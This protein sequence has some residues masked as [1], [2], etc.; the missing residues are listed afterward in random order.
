M[1]VDTKKPIKF[2]TDYVLMELVDKGALA[3][4]AI[5]ADEDVERGLFKGIKVQINPETNVTTTYIILSNNKKDLVLMDLN[6]FDFLLIETFANTT[7]EM[8][9]YKGVKE[10]QDAAFNQT[11]A[12]MSDMI[13]EERVTA[14]KDLI[15]LESYTSIPDSFGTGVAK[16]I[17]KDVTKVPSRAVAAGAGNALKSQVNPTHTSLAYGPGVNQHTNSVYGHQNFA[18]HAAHSTYDTTYVAKG[19]RKPTA[20]KRKTKKPTAAMIKVLK[21]SLVAIAENT[22][23]APELPHPDIERVA[24]RSSVYPYDFDGY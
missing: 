18:N 15:N 7:R 9:L 4:G 10:D 21:A 11:V 2:K 1:V 16:A 19:D 24:E 12:L 13:T 14:D 17:I 5:K 22:Y 8:V 20:F 6:Y 3:E 23:V